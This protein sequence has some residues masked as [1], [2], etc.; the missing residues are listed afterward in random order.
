MTD[1]I[2]QNIGKLINTLRSKNG[3]VNIV[4]STIFPV[5]GKEDVV[6]L[7]NLKIARYVQSNSTLRQPVVLADQ[8]EGFDVSRDLTHGG[9]LPNATGARK[10][11]RVFAG[12]IHNLF[13]NAEHKSPDSR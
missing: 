6:N 8:H 11:A 9:T 10:M 5:M 2:V 7:L 12:V 3:K 4:L 13:G 1:G